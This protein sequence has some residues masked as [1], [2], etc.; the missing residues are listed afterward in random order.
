MVIRLVAYL[1][2]CFCGWHGK[3]I[4]ADGRASKEISNKQSALEAMEVAI[5]AGWL[6]KEEVLFLRDQIESSSL[7]RDAEESGSWE[8]MVELAKEIF[9]QS[10]E[11]PKTTTVHST[12]PAVTIH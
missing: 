4:L 6:T 5:D 10:D 11:S 7:P 1:D 2:V 3:I 8:F 9:S 12:K